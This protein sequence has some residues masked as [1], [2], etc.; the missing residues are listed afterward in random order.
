MYN[1]TKGDALRVEQNHFMAEEIGDTVI[2]L[3]ENGKRVT[4]GNIVDLLER[5]RHALHGNK[6]DQI[7]EIL[8]FIRKKSVM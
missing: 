3:L 5:K 8:I 6:A 7:R 2:Q 4:T 1:H